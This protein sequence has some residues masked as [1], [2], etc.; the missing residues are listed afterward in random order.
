MVPKPAAEKQKC[1]FCNVA[2][3]GGVG[4]ECVECL[5]VCL[6]VCLGLSLNL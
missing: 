2:D 5:F 6:P 1:V 4:A 3:C